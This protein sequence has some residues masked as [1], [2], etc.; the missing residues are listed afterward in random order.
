MIKFEYEQYRPVRQIWAWLAVFFLSV[1]TM[2]WGMIGHLLVREGPR[3]WDFG[4]LPDTPGQSVFS[5]VQPPEGEVVP[6]QIQLPPDLSTD[7]REP[8]AE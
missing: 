4:S 8:N 7:E 3:R 6:P 1:S 2:A 5:T